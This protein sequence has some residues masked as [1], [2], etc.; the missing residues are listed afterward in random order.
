ML[1]LRFEVGELGVIQRKVVYN[2]NTFL[3]II[4]LGNAQMLAS[5]SNGLPSYCSKL[6]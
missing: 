5:P 6:R 4:G 3:I 2:K 1:V